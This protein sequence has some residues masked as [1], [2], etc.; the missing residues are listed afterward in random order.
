MKFGLF[1]GLLV[2]LA[3]T[4]VFGARKTTERPDLA[5]LAEPTQSDLENTAVKTQKQF[6]NSNAREPVDR[7]ND[8]TTPR[9]EED[10]EKLEH[11]GAETV[12]RKNDRT[13]PRPEG[14]GE[15]LEHQGAETD[16]SNVRKSSKIEAVL[17][18]GEPV[19]QPLVIL[20]VE[21]CIKAFSS[22]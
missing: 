15:K 8:R 20:P 10:G 6:S 5:D 12:D 1:V 4:N 2:L 9:P 18:G 17:V 22:E 7:K 16:D 21:V 3:S 19:K 13:K 11:Q 14:D